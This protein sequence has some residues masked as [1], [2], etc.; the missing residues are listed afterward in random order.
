MLVM[1][2]VVHEFEDGFGGVA[3]A[4]GGLGSLRRRTM[5]DKVGAKAGRLGRR[6]ERGKNGSNGL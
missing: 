2:V 1:L 6:A 3:M 5:A 4:S